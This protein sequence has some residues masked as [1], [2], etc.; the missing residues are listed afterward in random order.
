MPTDVYFIGAEKPLKLADDYESVT[1]K[2]LQGGR[3]GHFS[4]RGS[5][6]R[7]TIYTSGIAYIEETS[8]AAEPV[9][10]RA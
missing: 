6:T 5:D 1:S 2:L 7:V 9:V 3:P 4:H 8:E 10:A